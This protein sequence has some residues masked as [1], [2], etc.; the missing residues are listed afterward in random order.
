[1][2]NSYFKLVQTREGFGIQIF[3]PQDGGE[4]LKI[5]EVSEYLSARNLLCDIPV[6]NNALHT[7][8]TIVVPLGSGSC[9]IERESFK[10][11]V[12][13]DNMS[14]VV[15]FYP[16]S[17]TGKM[18]DVEEFISELRLKKVT[19]GIQRENIENYFKNR[20][21]CTNILVAVGKEPRHGKDA[22]IE[23]FFS[24]DLRAKPTLKEDGSVDFFHLNTINHCKKD[25]ILARLIPEDPGE[26]GEDVLGAKIKPKTVKKEMLK[27]N[28]NTWLSEDKL[29][30]FSSVDGHVLLVDD[31]VF[32][33]NVYQVENVDNST[34]DIEYNGSVEIRGNV[35]T[36]F[37]VKA[38]GNIVVNGVVEGAF[39]EAEGDIIIARGM[40]GMN[41]GAL[42]AGGN[43]VAKFL[44]NA[45][46]TAGGYVSTEAILHSTVM[47][48]T[49]VTVD[50]RRGFIVGGRV[51]ATNTIKVKTLGSSMGAATLVEVG[52]D[53]RIKV[54]YQENQKQILE[55]SKI[56]KSL[57]P[58]I[59][60][61]AYKRKQGMQMTTDQL[62]YL[63]SVLK[64]REVKQEE[65]E[66]LVR[67]QNNLQSMLDMQGHASVVVTGEVF[68]GTKIAIADVSTVVQ[69]SRK[70]C[71]YVKLDGDVKVVSI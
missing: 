25:E 18:I 51:S 13:P 71:K 40:N 54:E 7:K 63:K 41:K 66:K 1:M 19:A 10:L 14:A 27:G 47:A 44:E 50:G 45:K 69:N 36:N 28:Q 46:V 53:P 20:Q 56:L 6:I 26:Y 11:V 34:G 58:V 5:S 15:R 42:R 39:L 31:K 8:E 4:E 49:D 48:G 32:V 55:L 33:S 60:T 17:D 64:L 38:N 52:T 16:P 29:E 30:L 68:S 35:S 70:Y 2:I 67:R 57:E 43:V 65:M 9:P 23:Y 37:S 59:T 3:P 22:Q 12:S 24:V 21:Y 61:Y 62:N